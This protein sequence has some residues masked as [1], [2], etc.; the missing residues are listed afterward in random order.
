MKIFMPA[1]ALLLVLLLEAPVGAAPIFADVTL[2]G[3]HLWSLDTFIVE[4]YWTERINVTS[5]V[6][7]QFTLG[8]PTFDGTFY[9]LDTVL[10]SFGCGTFQVDAYWH[11]GWFGEI[12]RTGTPCT[13]T[14]VCL[15]CRTPEIPQ[16]P[17]PEPPAWFLVG[18]GLCIALWRLSPWR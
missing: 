9:R 18:L 1:V 11:G 14:P 16:T 7:N 10:P 4:G 3:V 5:T 13:F 15:T 8:S 17:V 2:D 12:Q 6:D